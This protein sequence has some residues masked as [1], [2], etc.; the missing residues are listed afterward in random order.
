MALVQTAY[1]PRVTPFPSPA[2]VAHAQES[3]RQQQYHNLICTHYAKRQ[4]L[5]QKETSLHHA[6]QRLDATRWNLKIAY[7]HTRGQFKL[8]YEHNRGQSIRQERRQIFFQ[9]GQLKERVDDLRV[10][11]SVIRDQIR[12]CDEDFRVALSDALPL[13][14]IPYWP[15]PG[16]VW[17]GDAPVFDPISDP[18]VDSAFVPVPS[19]GYAE[20]ISPESSVDDQFSSPRSSSSVLSPLSQVFHAPGVEDNTDTIPEAP[21]TT[22]QTSFTTQDTVDSAIDAATQAL[23][24]LEVEISA[25][26]ST[27]EALSADDAGEK[28]DTNAP[29]TAQ[30]QG[31]SEWNG[32]PHREDLRQ[33]RYSMS[34]LKERTY[35][36]PV[37][38]MET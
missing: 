19:P 3:F 6:I 16:S 38:Y 36:V 4:E 35:E 20:T 22:P 34:D 25:D 26:D 1:G 30:D 21:C 23:V 10:E 37:E 27:H 14:S 32:I 31:E 33:R 18:N 24:G 15:P 29:E 12:T 2:M 8:A 13:L 17:P 28:D 7:E 11:L 5:T 9:M